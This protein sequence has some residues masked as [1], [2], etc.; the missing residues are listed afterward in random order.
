MDQRESKIL[1]D[2]QEVQGLECLVTMPTRVTDTT[3][4]LLDKACGVYNPEVSN[5]AMIYG[6]LDE[7]VKHHQSNL[8][9]FR[10]FKNLNVE[11]LK[12]N[13]RTAPWHVGEMFESVDDSYCYW[14]ALLNRIL[15]EEKEEEEEEEEEE[16]FI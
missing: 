6:L 5:Y 9:T 14:I 7:K 15:E 13:L 8:V 10:D 3:E 16:Y 11:S 2:L 1:R 12:E 4:S